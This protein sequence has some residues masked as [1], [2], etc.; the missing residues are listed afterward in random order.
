MAKP[1]PCTREGK[2]ALI[3]SR[4]T[5]GL[6]SSSTVLP[7]MDSEAEWQEFRDAVLADLE[8]SDAAEVA[9]IRMIAS[10]LWRLRRAANAE[11]ALYATLPLSSAPPAAALEAIG[12]HE[13]RVKGELHRALRALY[14]KRVRIEE[15]K[16]T[17]HL[18]FEKG[19]RA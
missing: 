15:I 10:A 3:R 9:L 4:V 19:S 5:H 17:D 14:S 6:T 8:P 13:T 11:A 12:R 2:A 16:T 7:G 18:R 1:G